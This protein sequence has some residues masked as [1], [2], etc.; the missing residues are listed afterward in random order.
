MGIKGKIALSTRDI[1][2]LFHPLNEKPRTL[3]FK[4]TPFHHTARYLSVINA[5][6]RR[7]CGDLKHGPLIINENPCLKNGGS[8]GQIC[9]VL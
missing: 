1:Y 7:I 8:N 6:L 9:V 3:C 5:R 4:Q 2:L